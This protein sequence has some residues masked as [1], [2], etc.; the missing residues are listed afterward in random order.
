M[1]RINTGAFPRSATLMGCCI[2]S[3]LPL[4]V[5][6]GRPG[7]LLFPGSSPCFGLF[8]VRKHEKNGTIQREWF[9]VAMSHYHNPVFV[10]VV[11]WLPPERQPKSCA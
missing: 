11:P 10:P 3:P 1:R 2:C 9:G 6:T 8:A 5:L 7:R 4:L